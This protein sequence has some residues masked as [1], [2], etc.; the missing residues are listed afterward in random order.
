MY[1]APIDVVIGRDA[2]ARWSDIHR[3]QGDR[4]KVREEAGKSSLIMTGRNDFQATDKRL[5]FVAT[6]DPVDD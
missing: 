3:R 5:D 1:T 6:P 4:D 2:E